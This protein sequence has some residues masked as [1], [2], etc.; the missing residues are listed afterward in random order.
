MFVFQENSNGF[1]VSCEGGEGSSLQKGM[2]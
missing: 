2:V 1:M